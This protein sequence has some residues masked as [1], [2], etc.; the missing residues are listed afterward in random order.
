MTTIPDILFVRRV[1]SFLL[2]S[3]G[4]VCNI[5]VKKDEVIMG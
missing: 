5:M 4:N 2:Q 1:I 3:T